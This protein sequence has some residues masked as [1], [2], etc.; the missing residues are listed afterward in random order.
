MHL[1]QTSPRS[2]AMLYAQ[3]Y[4]YIH[5]STKVVFRCPPISCIRT[6]NTCEQNDAELSTA[7]NLFWL[8]STYIHLTCYNNGTELK[9]NLM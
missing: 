1:A 2:M 9:E 7:A 6:A 5:V 3:T 8:V 4:T